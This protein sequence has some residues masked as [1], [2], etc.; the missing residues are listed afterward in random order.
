VPALIDF[1]YD[2][3]LP[4][5]WQWQAGVQTAMPWA[6][7]V[8]V[9]YVGNHGFNRLRAFQGGANGAVD[10]NA[11]DIGAAY[12][13][14]N[15][16]PTLG[17]NAVPGASAYTTNLLRAYRG[18]AAINEQQTRF[19]DEY[20]GLQ[21]SVN[22][23][24]QNGVAFG[25]NYN[26]GLSLKGNTGL[27]LRLQHAA[28]GT[29]SVRSDQAQYEALN[30][31]LALQRHVIK[32]FA[33]WDLPNLHSGSS[34]AR[35]LLNDW[36]ISGVLTAG[37]AFQPGAIQSNGAAQA[38][39]GPDANGRYDI[40]YSYQNNG[41]AV[42]LTGSPDYLARILYVGDP[43]SGCSDNQYAQFNTAA[44]KGPGYGSTGLESGRFLLGGCPDHTVDLA[45]A[46]NIKFGG[47]RSFQFRLDI[48]NAFNTVIYND[49]N[50]DVIYRSPTDQTIVNSQYLPDGSL[51]PARLT[52]RNA[53][54]GAAT[55]AQPLR[56]L[57]LQLRF[58]F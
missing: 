38:N 55:S 29:M 32:S 4:S 15:Q 48:F 14:Q 7:A 33:V 5:S 8:D 49:R 44:V 19:W 13:A 54:F 22:R 1:Q 35:W 20:H 9:S 39:R 25:T 24:Y 56:N 18:F 36:Q 31:N 47:N 16:D 21:M 51:D 11:V 28:D 53:G 37:S 10:L 40:N 52:P 58:Q 17:P 50:R 41:A 30:E 43:G 46:R 34:V 45:I 3:K 26:L 6:M 27:Q 57:Q 42:N 2:A 23:R 12:L